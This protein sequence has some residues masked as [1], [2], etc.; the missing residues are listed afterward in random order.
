MPG[1]LRRIVANIKRRILPED[2]QL[3]MYV[4]FSDGSVMIEILS[5]KEFQKI[6]KAKDWTTAT[7]WLENRYCGLG[8]KRVEVK[9]GDHMILSEDN[10][11][12]QL[13]VV[14]S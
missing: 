6:R 9:F 4:V 14:Q 11:V 12:P 10:G 1:L 7:A 2:G 5:S 3:N 8:I 13:R